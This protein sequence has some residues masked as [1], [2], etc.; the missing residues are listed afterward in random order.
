MAYNLPL[1]GVVS[2]SQ[3]LDPI[4]RSTFHLMCSCNCANVI[5][6]IFDFK[7]SDVLWL[8]K[9]ILV[10]H[11]I[12]QVSIVGTCVKPILSIFDFVT[13][14]NFLFF[15]VYSSLRIAVKNNIWLE[16]I[17]S[18]LS[19]LIKTSHTPFYKFLG[20]PFLVLSIWNTRE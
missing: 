1:N 9:V 4:E 2:S 20:L 3:C 14:E 6:S 17:I 13:S 19:K 18:L 16:I 12:H 5:L 15:K 10:Y 11:S 7:A 8:P